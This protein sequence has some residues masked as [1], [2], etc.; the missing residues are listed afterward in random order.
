MSPEGDGLFR[1]FRA[2][3]LSG[4]SAGLMPISAKISRSRADRYPKMSNIEQG[5]L[6]FEEYS[7]LLRFDISCSTFDIQHPIQ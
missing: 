7:L 1:P 2:S 5:M 6:N 4:T 3:R